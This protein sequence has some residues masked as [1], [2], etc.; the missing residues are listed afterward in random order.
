M[1]NLSFSD[2]IVVVSRPMKDELVARG[3][4]PEKILVNPNGVDP[5]RYSPEIDGSAVRSKYGLNGKL[6]IGFIGTFGK[7]H[8]AGA[9][10][11][12]RNG[13]VPPR[14]QPRWHPFLRLSHQAVRV[15][16]DGERDRR[17]PPGPD[18]RN[19]RAWADGL[20]GRTGRCGV[21]G[22]PVGKACRGRA[23]AEKSGRS[24]AAR[25]DGEKH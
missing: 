21:L 1:V 2:L 25:G 23:P 24:A 14:S 10:G 9:P 11:G 18:R 22:G 13:G 7:L 8:G 5:E 15:H 4:D 16:G 3:I 20:D 6:V 19:T 12:L 17:V